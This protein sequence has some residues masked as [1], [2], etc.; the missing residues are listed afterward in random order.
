M[1]GFDVIKDS[2]GKEY[3]VFDSGELY[4]DS[5]MG[6]KSDDFEILKKLGE[7]AFGKVFKVRS[8]I[9]NKIYAMKRLNIKAIREDNE[10]A[11]QLT[12]N[13]T[14]FLE[15]LNHPHIIKYYKNFTEGDI[16]Y[17]IIEFIANGDMNGFIEAHKKFK[18]NIEEE[19]LW[20]LFLQCMEALSYVHSMG[21]IHRD[22]KPA[23]LLMDNNM[24]IK[25][26]DF[27]V[28]ALQNKDSNNQYLNANYNIFKNKDNMKYHGTCVGTSPYMAKEI[29]K[30]EYDQKVDVYAMGISFFEM[31]YFFNPKIEKNKQINV[32][33]SNELVNI[34]SLMIEEDKNKRKTSAEI[35][36]MIRNIYVNKYLK[37][38]STDAVARCLSSINELNNNFANIPKNLMQRNPVCNAY[39]NCLGAITNPNL[40]A[41]VNSVNNLRNFI[42][43]QNP[44]LEGTKEIEPR[45]VLACLLGQLHKELNAPPTE[46]D[47]SNKYLIISGEEEAKTSKIEM[48][49]KFIND[50]LIKFNSFVSRDFMGYMK[51]TNICSECELKTFSFNSYFFVTF[52]LEKILKQNNIS[53]VDVENCFGLQNQKKMNQLV[54][55]SK[56]LNRTNQFCFKQFYS[57]PNILVISIQ[58]GIT[59][60][61]K[62]PVNVKENLD[63]TECAEFKFCKK[64][65]NLTGLIGRYLNNGIERFFSVVKFN[66]LWLYCEGTN[67][68][69][70]NNLSEANSKGDILMLFYNGVE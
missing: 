35:L 14:S 32:Q 62:T 26:G 60:N 23:N 53:M 4:D 65:F 46:K 12:I 42:V 31:C 51:L 43:A 44:K 34:I 48:M 64:K 5:Q 68:N 7:G 66:Q 50:M 54:Y 28:S 58:R 29:E 45:T 22:I 55:C 9:N 15:G 11:Y 8:K 52:D 57:L 47:K 18:K 27:G 69:Q 56:C 70:I 49:M 30:N 6:N 36:N 3:L 10:K 1:S 19:Q 40:Y 33:Y 16:L 61:Y 24:S 67:I 17:I 39:M 38:T 21:V 59:Y 13:E 20:N 41:W 63:L 25:L 2:E 37:N